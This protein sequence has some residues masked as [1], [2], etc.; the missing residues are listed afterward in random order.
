[1]EQ[2][3]LGENSWFE[4]GLRSGHPREGLCFWLTLCWPRRL[5]LQS[6]AIVE[7]SDSFYNR[8]SEQ[9]CEQALITF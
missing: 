4:T 2:F 6:D 7:H 9:H 5:S 8:L 3:P 1:M